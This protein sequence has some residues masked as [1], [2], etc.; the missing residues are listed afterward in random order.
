MMYNQDNKFQVTGEQTHENI[1]FENMRHYRKQ[2]TQLLEE[3]NII[4]V[5]NYK[6]EDYSIDMYIPILSIGISFYKCSFNKQNYIKNMLECEYYII[7]DDYSLRKVLCQIMIRII[8]SIHSIQLANELCNAESEIDK[9]LIMNNYYRYVVLPMKRTA[10]LQKRIINLSG[11]T[12]IQNDCDCD[13]NCNMKNSQK[14][15]SLLRLRNK[16]YK[17][18]MNKK[19]DNMTIYDDND[20]GKLKALTR[21]NKYMGYIY[22]LEWDDMVKIGYTTNPY[23]RYNELKS[24]AENYSKS[25]IGKFALSREHTNYKNNEYKLHQHFKKHR[26]KGTELFDVTI[27]QVITEIPKC[28]LFL[29]ESKEI[30]EKTKQEVNTISKIWGWGKYKK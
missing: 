7:A 20:I 19:T 27:H 2:I 6:V 23:K 4:Y 24:Y 14:T 10:E 29:N 26:K 11:N 16:K 1:F 30:K 21:T 9:A 25:H 15:I 3:Y 5:D 17:I 28:L 22:A 12:D 8:N 18:I 13:D